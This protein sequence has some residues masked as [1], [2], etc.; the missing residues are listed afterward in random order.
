MADTVIRAFPYRAGWLVLGLVAF[1]FV[2]VAVFGAAMGCTATQPLPI[3]SGRGGQAV[4]T[5]SPE[6][7]RVLGWVIGACGA[8]GVGATLASIKAQRL[9]PRRVAVTP[10]QL[11]VP[12]STFSSREKAIERAAITDVSA[13]GPRYRRVLSVTHTGGRCA[14]AEAL[15]PSAKA[16]DELVEALGGSA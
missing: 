2:V 13:T 11:I 5:L 9:S 14:I 7:V 16:F 1:I 6:Q 10:T 8:A 3:G 4:V 15:L 12:A